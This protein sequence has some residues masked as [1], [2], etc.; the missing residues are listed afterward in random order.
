VN[1][2]HADSDRSGFHLHR[3][4]RAPV[5]CAAMLAVLLAAPLSA[6]GGPAEGRP[7]PEFPR[8]D[9]SEWIN[10][11]PLTLEALK[12]SPVLLEIWTFG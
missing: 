11:K 9:A 4:A 1:V 6:A 7:A 12:G 10:S 8:K 5:L 3:P 2:R